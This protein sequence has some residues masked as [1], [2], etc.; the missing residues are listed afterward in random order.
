[1]KDSM[2]S[3]A[4]PKECEPPFWADLSILFQHFSLQYKPTCE[5]SVI[6]FVTRLLILSLF[7][8]MI[9]SVVGGLSAIPVFL[10]FGG[11]TA[12]VIIYTTPL[13]KHGG[14]HAHGGKH[15]DKLSRDDKYAALRS[16]HGE[17]EDR[18]QLPY[19]TA[20][21][22]EPSGYIAPIK[23]HFVNGGAEKGSVQPTV[24]HLNAG[25]IGVEE[26]DGFPYAG[27]NLPDYT[28]PTSRNL[29]M[30]V[31][32][33][34]QKY[35]PGRPAAAPVSDPTVKQTMDDYFRV[36]W[37]SDPTD[38]FGKN[39]GQRQFVTQPSTTVPNDQGSFADWLYKI[40]GKTC[41]E[42]GREAC[43]AGSDGSA[44]PWLNQAS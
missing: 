35:N 42:G 23:E 44:I 31:L 24:S 1:M 3:K 2:D 40:P 41:K 17:H 27:P 15:S 32:V 43:L 36:Q 21:H 38:V 33:D 29:F 11:I 30:N 14:K 4:N 22:L 25:P 20:P 28:P 12:A 26:V 18:G 19:H 16:V 8:G 7:V 10:L 13:R 34:E 6:N 9:A 37:F 39:Q 5:H